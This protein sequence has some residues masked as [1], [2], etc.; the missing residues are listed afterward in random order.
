MEEREAS[1]G[2]SLTDFY[3]SD[4]KPETPASDSHHD[5]VLAKRKAE[6]VAPALDKK[7]K[8][9]DGAYSPST[10][11][12]DSC[13]GLPAEIWQHIFLSCSIR[14][15][16]RLLK[17]NRSF[18][19]YL[20]RVQTVPHSKPAVGFVRLIKSE[21][22]WASARNAHPTKPPG[23]LPGFSEVDMWRLILGKTCQFCGKL[24]SSSPGE[25]SWEKGPGEN[26]VRIIWPFGVRACG[27][28]LLQRCEKVNCIAS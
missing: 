27:P 26:G 13:A 17:V 4:R 24:P 16:G 7:R 6:D 2:A 5:P 11:R 20:T 18:H 10:V 8:L 14:T 22:I 28:C 15:L 3:D 25:K 21:S 19:S 1:V 9:D 23:P 12:L